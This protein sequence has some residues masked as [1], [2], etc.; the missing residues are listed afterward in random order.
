MRE[1][2]LPLSFYLAK[3]FARETA[4]ARRVRLAEPQKSGP[5]IEMPPCSQPTTASGT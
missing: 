1:G 3:G 5:W 4:A 2:S